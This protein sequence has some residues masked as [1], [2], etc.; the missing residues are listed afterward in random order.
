[1]RQQERLGILILSPTTDRGGF[2]QIPQCQY[3]VETALSALVCQVLLTS[4]TWL[5]VLGRQVD[6]VQFQVRST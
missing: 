3:L 5:G 4:Q 6:L 1:M 2:D